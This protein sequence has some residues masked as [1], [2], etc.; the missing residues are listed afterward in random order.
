MLL[1]FVRCFR[2]QIKRWKA[3]KIN[4]HDDVNEEIEMEW[5]NESRK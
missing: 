2:E 1:S 3:R 5:N 4:K